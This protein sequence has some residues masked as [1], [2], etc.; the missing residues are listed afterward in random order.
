MEIPIALQVIGVICGCAAFIALF[1]L[2]IF[3]IQ[4][5]YESLEMRRRRRSVG[6]FRSA[7][8]IE[9]ERV[10]SFRR[11]AEA[12]QTLGKQTGNR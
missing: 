1:L 4:A 6:D 9:R 7:R 3:G 12:Y 5:A 2:I 8:Q 11:L 10:E